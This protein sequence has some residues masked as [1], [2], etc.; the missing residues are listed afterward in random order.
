MAI[1]LLADHGQRDLIFL[2]VDFFS[3]LVNNKIVG[4]YE[5][6][7]TLCILLPTIGSRSVKHYRAFKCKRSCCFAGSSKWR[8]DH[9]SSCIWVW[10]FL[11]SLLQ[12]MSRTTSS[13]PWCSPLCSGCRILHPQLSAKHGVFPLIA[14]SSGV[15]QD[16]WVPGLWHNEIISHHIQLRVK[17][18]NFL[19]SEI[20]WNSESESPQTSSQHDSF[21]CLCLS[22][23]IQE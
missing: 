12:Q 4:S 8:R 20:Q 2:C 22:A 21:R 6:N 15:S 3:C 19:C 10:D 1:D 5:W 23:E 11:P 16:Y 17:E 14:D 7:I 9:G 18:H 13:A